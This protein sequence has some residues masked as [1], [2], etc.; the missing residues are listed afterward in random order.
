LGSAG[1]SNL[2]FQIW[3]SQRD[4]FVVVGLEAIAFSVAQRFIN[5]ADVAVARGIDPDKYAIGLGQSYV[6][7]LLGLSPLCRSFDVRRYE[8]ILRANG[9]ANLN[10]SEFCD[11]APWHI[12]APFVYAGTRNH[13][14]QYLNRQNEVPVATS[15]A[16]L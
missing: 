14:R 11:P 12:E 6:H 1:I 5:L 9:M 16:G 10:D 13:R 15:G 7:E 2:K 4:G 3:K 8:E